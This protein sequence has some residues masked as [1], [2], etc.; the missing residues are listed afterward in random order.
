MDTGHILRVLEILELNH[1]YIVV[2]SPNDIRMGLR[3]VLPLT[4][5]IARGTDP[6]E[7][8]VSGVVAEAVWDSR[9]EICT[10][11]LIN[12]EL[13]NLYKLD[14][15]DVYDEIVYWW[16]EQTEPNVAMNEAKDVAVIYSEKYQKFKRIK[17][18]L[19]LL[20]LFGKRRRI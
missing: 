7:L 13:E 15:W 10:F 3:Y 6:I 19:D 2:R 14:S 18:K 12:L 4:V 8:E 11:K 16:E 20:R 5:P 1:R 9:N 17:E